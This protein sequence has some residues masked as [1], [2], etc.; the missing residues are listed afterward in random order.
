MNKALTILKWIANVVMGIVL[1]LGILDT[2]GMSMVTNMIPSGPDDL[3]TTTITVKSIE[4][5]PQGFLLTSQEYPTNFVAQLIPPP[6]NFKTLVQ[7]GHKV[8]LSV[9]KEAA[10]KLASTKIL[11]FYKLTLED[12]QQVFD[13][14]NTIVS[15]PPDAAATA[16]AMFHRMIIIPLIY[17]VALLLYPS[18]RRQFT[19]KA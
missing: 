15:I 10:D 19:K 16:Q 14:T 4:T 8:N 11:Q 18:V 2:F 13:T 12:G 5:T 9:K 17:F 1:I 7:V 6:E 3:A